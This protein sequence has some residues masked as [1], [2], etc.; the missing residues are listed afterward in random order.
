MTQPSA[1]PQST[2]LAPNLAGALAY[3]LGPI[4]GVFFLVT[5]KENRFIRFHA[6]QST[7][8]SI[9][10]IAMAVVLIVLEG[11]LAFIPVVGWLVGILL[12]L[13]LGLVGFVLW[14]LLMYRA[15]QGR[16]WVLPLVGPQAQRMAGAEPRRP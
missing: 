2:G 10:W 1:A 16:E 8:L 14:L 11:V 4:T 9:A 5:E 7:V 6:A 12:S 15:F 13:G 3:L